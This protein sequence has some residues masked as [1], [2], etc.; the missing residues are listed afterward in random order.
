MDFAVPEPDRDKQLAV[1][2]DNMTVVKELAG[3]DWVDAE[4]SAVRQGDVLVRV[5]GAAVDWLPGSDRPVLL[6]TLH[7]ANVGPLRPVTYDGQ[8]S[9]QHPAVL[10]DGLGKELAR[11]DLGPQ[12]LKAGQ[13]HTVSVLPTHEVQDVVASEPPWPGSDRVDLELPAAAWG[14]QGVCHF[15]IPR[16]FIIHKRR[17]K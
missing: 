1:F 6:V 2:R 10:R 17:P 15:R 11:R 7:V 8:G 3:E 16:T 9:G 14:G 13:V 4:T 12:A 5:E